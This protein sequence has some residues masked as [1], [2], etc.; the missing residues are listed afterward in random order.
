MF[1]RS[2]FY[3]QRYT[4]KIADPI[5]NNAKIRVSLVCLP[6]TAEPICSINQSKAL[7]LK[8]VSFMSRARAK[9]SRPSRLLVIHPTSPT[10]Y[11]NY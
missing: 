1:H 4:C 6:F 3:K 10:G 2:W 11:I 8:M 7:K 9:W 5:T